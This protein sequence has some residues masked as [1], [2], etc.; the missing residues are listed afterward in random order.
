M[1]WPCPAG[2]PDLDRGPG[3]G[4]GCCCRTS[5]GSGW[6]RRCGSAAG[7][8]CTCCW[9]WCGG[10]PPSPGRARARSPGGGGRSV[11]SG[12]GGVHRGRPPAGTVRPLRRTD[13]PGP[14]EPRPHGHR[15]IPQGLGR[16]PPVTRTERAGHTAPTTGHGPVDGHGARG[17]RRGHRWTPASRPDA[18]NPPTRPQPVTRTE[19]AGHTAPTTGH[20]PVD[21]HGARAAGRGHRWTPASRPDAGNPPTRPQPVPRL[22]VGDRGRHRPAHRAVT[23]LPPTPVSRPSPP[24]PRPHRRRTPLASY[25]GG[26]PGS[27]RR[28]RRGGPPGG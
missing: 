20:G 8:G 6:T 23:R 2:V 24:H 28:L 9:A 5:P 11:P 1:R 15:T 21:G 14:R 18:G 10:R 27:R 25:A 7:R 3:P 16:T 19:R 4:Y 17:A 22:P 26:P 13:P 12:V